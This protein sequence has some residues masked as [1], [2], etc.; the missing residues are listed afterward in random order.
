LQKIYGNEVSV[1]EGLDKLA[2]SVQ[3]QLRDAG[4]TD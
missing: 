2:E 3:G 1:D 4:I